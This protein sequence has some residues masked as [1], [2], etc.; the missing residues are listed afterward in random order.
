MSHPHDISQGSTVA[1]I[2]SAERTTDVSDKAAVDGSADVHAY[3]DE[4]IQELGNGRRVVGAGALVLEGRVNADLIARALYQLQL[5]PD[6][7]AGAAGYNA[8][9][10]A[11]DEAT[12]RRQYFHAADDS[13]NAHSWLAREVAARIKGRFF[14]S[15][16]IA[17]TTPEEK[18]F[19]HQTVSALFT[20]LYSRRRLRVT[21]EGR[22]TFARTAAEDLAGAIY[23]ARDDECARFFY[24]PTLYPALSLSIGDKRDPGLQV[25]DVLLWASLQTEYSARSKKAAI[26]NW[27]GMRRAVHAARSASDGRAETPSFV[28]YGVNCDYTAL[29]KQQ[30]ARP[31][32]PVNLSEV[33]AESVDFMMAYSLF[34]SAL[35]LL[36]D[37]LGAELP[38]H[39]KHLEADAR[40][41]LRR[42]H[43]E[44]TP[45]HVTDLCRQFVRL[46]DTVP[47]YPAQEDASEWIRRLR[48]KRVLALL[49]GP[50]HGDGE[51]LARYFAQEWARAG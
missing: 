9:A 51:E 10:A 18:H 24:M 34:R 37:A 31:D 30:G 1:V 5:D 49:V 42:L 11:L 13:K 47:L 25:A 41:A 45:E 15:F 33:Q 36:R 12:L 17:S 50:G 43:A 32:Y 7:Y 26:A 35:V 8:L 19:R 22:T 29:L 4:T 2:P 40:G 3:V 46:F 6:R 48:I 39:A 28:A 14:C 27:C 23:Q 44:C 16:A 38:G 21:F 20:P